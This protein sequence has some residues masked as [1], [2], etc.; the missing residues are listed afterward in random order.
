DIVCPDA[1]EL[2]KQDGVKVL[3]VGCAKGFWLE[4]V[5]M[6]NPFGEYHGVD[7][8]ENLASEPEKSGQNNITIKFG[9]VL[10]RL[11][12]E[13][14]AFDYVHQRLL[15]LGMPKERFPDA[16]REL[17]RV[18]KPGGWI[19]LVESDMMLYDSGPYSKI[20][21]AAFLDAL[22][23]RGLDCYAAT[24]LEY[25]ASQVAANV[26]NQGVTTVILPTHEDTP[27]GRLSERNGKI[28]LLGLEDWLHK[29]MN[30]TREEYR[31]LIENCFTEFLEYN[32]YGLAR[33]LYFQVVK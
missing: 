5:R 2:V 6:A 33:A 29:S 16:L 18:T 25:Y 30:I 22:Q 3:D 27:L 13:D 26:S 7:I 15:V 19:E 11:P 31:E 32:S 24:N 14:N 21:R 23:A 10:E 20:F 4:S 8:A 17:I 1:K 12:Y 28:G 9:N